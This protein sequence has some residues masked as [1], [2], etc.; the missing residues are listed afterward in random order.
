MEKIANGENSK[1]YDLVKSKLYNWS[2]QAVQSD[3]SKLYK[4]IKASCKIRSKQAVQKRQGD[5]KIKKAVHYCFCLI[6]IDALIVTLCKLREFWLFSYSFRF[7][8]PSNLHTL[9]LL[10]CKTLS[11]QHI[12]KLYNYNTPHNN[13]IN[14][15]ISIM[16]L[17]LFIKAI[18]YSLTSDLN[19]HTLIVFF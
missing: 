6:I 8:N 1:L 9:T 7:S 10:G 12:S 5:H 15:F 18:S 2:Q 11:Y 4:Q 13:T 19:Q 3:Q 14:I 17:F 16:N